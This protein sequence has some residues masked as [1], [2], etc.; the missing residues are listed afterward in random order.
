MKLCVV[1]ADRSMADFLYFFF[2]S[3]ASSTASTSLLSGGV[4]LGGTGAENGKNTPG[5]LE[6]DL[7]LG[8]GTSDELLH[9]RYVNCTLK[10]S[11]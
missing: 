10:V 8:K 6:E 3:D 2:F 11:S 1:V 7:D 9:S 5:P 4:Q